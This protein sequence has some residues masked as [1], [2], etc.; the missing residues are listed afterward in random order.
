MN[1]EPQR[2]SGGAT[3]GPPAGGPVEQIKAESLNRV[4]EAGEGAYLVEVFERHL[5][6]DIGPWTY[7]GMLVGLRIL[8][9]Y[10]LLSTVTWAVQAPAESVDEVLSSEGMTPAARDLVKRIVTLYG[11]KAVEALYASPTVVHDGDDWR[12]VLPEVVWNPGTGRYSISVEI[13]K[14]N[15][16]TFVVRSEPR[17]LIRWVRIMA[18]AVAE[19]A[20]PSQFPESD[21][22]SLIE[23]MDAVRTALDQSGREE[24][25]TSEQSLVS[26]DIPDEGQSGAPDA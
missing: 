16:D 26:A 23:A 11:A 1:D 14:K 4:V 17:S 6:G 9:P 19:F 5:V 21:R 18:I 15:L 22:A 12:S 25:A 13:I 7:E 24:G 20:D 2:G 8:M 10:R 3:E